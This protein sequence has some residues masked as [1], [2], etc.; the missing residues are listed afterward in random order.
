MVGL[1]ENG[2]QGLKAVARGAERDTIWPELTRRESGSSKLWVDA[3]FVTFSSR[4]FEFCSK[5]LF[6]FNPET[7]QNLFFY[8]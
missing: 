1:T 2:K 8:Y 4:G 6:S 3:V 7:N 5:I